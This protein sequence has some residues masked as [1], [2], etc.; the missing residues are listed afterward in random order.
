MHICKLHRDAKTLY[1]QGI[2][3]VS[4][5]EKPGIQAIERDGKTLPMVPG[6][7]ERREFNYIRHG[8]QVLTA[9]LHLGT[10]HNLCPTIAD[11]RTENDFAS[12]IDTL[13]K[14]DPEAT[15]ILLLDQLNTHNSEALV[16]YV[17][18][19]CQDTQDLGEK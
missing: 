9:N 5:D 18:K 6:K 8:T 2:H 11:T 12:H 3:V 19:V 1:A 14:T 17:A 13:I 16:Q 4:I 10:G 7:V 15:W